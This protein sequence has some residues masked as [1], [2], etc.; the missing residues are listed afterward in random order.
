MHCRQIVHVCYV[1]HADDVNLECR[2]LSEGVGEIYLR[3]EP[4]WAVDPG[5]PSPNSS[6]PSPKLGGCDRILY[7]VGSEV[8]SAC[9]TASNNADCWVKVQV[10]E[11]ETFSS[12]LTADPEGILQSHTGHQH[13]TSRALLVNDPSKRPKYAYQGWMLL[14]TGTEPSNPCGSI[15]DGQANLKYCGNMECLQ[16]LHGE[17]NGMYWKKPAQTTMLCSGPLADR[18]G[19]WPCLILRY[20]TERFG[21]RCN[22]S[23]HPTSQ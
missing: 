14:G 19:R 16:L 21:K 8:G 11:W 13:V 22:L 12:P 4:C 2:Q 5:S 3:P 18:G 20:G 6:Y 10:R 15:P 23:I 1:C 7:V 9:T 17:Y